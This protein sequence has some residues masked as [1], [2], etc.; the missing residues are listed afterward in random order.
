[1]LALLG[2]HHILHV[3]R[4]RVKLHCC[5]YLRTEIQINNSM[6]IQGNMWRKKTHFMF[7]LNCVC[8]CVGAHAQ[9]Q[10]TALTLAKDCRK[11]EVFGHNN[12]FTY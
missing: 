7:I 8:V 1:M 11:Q 6:L 9:A 12:Q 5:S 10:V 3:S 4:I 2:A